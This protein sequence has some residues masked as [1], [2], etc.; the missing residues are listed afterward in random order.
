MSDDHQVCSWYRYF[1]RRSGGGAYWT[2]SSES[3]LSLV[4]W[5]EPEEASP[6]DSIA[7]SP[8]ASPASS[9]PD[10]PEL[11]VSSLEELSWPAAADVP[12]RA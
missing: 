7:P 4:P 10:S 9:P 8:S 2:F 12:R 3:S 11:V 5:L 1:R 6:L